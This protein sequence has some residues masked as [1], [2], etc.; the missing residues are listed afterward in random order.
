MFL[1]NVILVTSP[2]LKYY[3]VLRVK[4]FIF[5]L[6]IY[7]CVCVCP[8]SFNVWIEDHMKSEIFPQVFTLHI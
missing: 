1:L 2:N 4:D 3:K 6:Y 5:A 7:M 8:V